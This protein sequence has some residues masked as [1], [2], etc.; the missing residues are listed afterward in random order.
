M[1]HGVCDTLAPVSNDGVVAYIAPMPNRIDS[2]ANGFHASYLA[3]NGTSVELLPGYE[4]N[5]EQYLGIYSKTTNVRI[6]ANREL[7]LFAAIVEYIST[8][9]TPPGSDVTIPTVLGTKLFVFDANGNSINTELSPTS[10]SIVPSQCHLAFADDNTLLL[11]GGPNLGLQLYKTPMA[12]LESSISAETGYTTGTA[13]ITGD[14]K[15]I[16][17]TRE[18]DNQRMICK[19]ETATGTITE[20]GLT[21]GTSVSDAQLTA[22]QDGLTIAFIRSSNTLVIATWESGIWKTTLLSGNQFSNPALSDDGQF[23]T[24][25]AKGSS[26]L[27]IY[28]YDHKNGVTKLISQNAGEEADADCTSPSISPDGTHVSFVSAAAN[29]GTESN[30]H[31]QILVAAVPLPIAT[32]QLQSGWNLCALSF[33]PDEASTALLN[34]AG[35]A[36]NWSD[37]RFVETTAFSA[38]QAFWIYASKAEKLHLKGSES[39]PTA[40]QKG[41]NLILPANYPNETFRNCYGYAGETYI[42][43]TQGSQSSTPAWCFLF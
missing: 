32:L 39:A 40:L 36:W 1:F 29:L 24:Y 35:T 33:A 42:K 3:Q 25:Q 4:R 41:W 10:G 21:A 27:Q 38:G 31:A 11:A 37:G 22:S 23:L 30:G 9:S 12:N 14:G 6:A 16:F 2:Q 15:K 19:Y 18:L 26:N 17:F 20:T 28:H 7:S 34:A 13:T 8:G 5:L 43:V